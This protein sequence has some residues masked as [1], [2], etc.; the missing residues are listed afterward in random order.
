MKIYHNQ[1]YGVGRVNYKAVIF[2]LDGT[3]VNSR[4]A[5]V[6]SWREACENYGLEFNL[7]KFMSQ[8]GKTSRDIAETLFNIE[9]EELEK[10]ISLK[11]RLF[12]RRY[13][14]YVKIFPDV[15]TTL[16]KLQKEGLKIGVASSNPRVV[17]RDVLDKL[18]I[19]K[20][21][22]EFVGDEDVNIGKPDPEILFKILKRLHV[23]PSEVVYVGDT[24]YD[25]LAGRKAGIRTVILVSDK[26]PQ[27]KILE[28]YKPDYIITEIKEIQDIILRNRTI[29]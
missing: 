27:G 14:D 21:V 10:L 29:H 9:K 24:A 22:K 25:V 19:L 13:I 3:L 12:V 17:I 4:M 16:K 8:V 7:M 15:E 6:K 1:N 23:Y 26:I 28:V 20:Y 2:D 5:H 18:G 11:T